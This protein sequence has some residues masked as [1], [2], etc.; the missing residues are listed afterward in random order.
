MKKNLI[1]FLTI[2]EFFNKKKTTKIFQKF[3]T[4]LLQKTYDEH[5]KNVLEN[6]TSK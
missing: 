1:F 6:L 4:N 5:T 2:F 3:Y